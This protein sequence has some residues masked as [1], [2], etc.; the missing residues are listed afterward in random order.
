VLKKRLDDRLNEKLRDARA[1][2]DRIVGT[3]KNKAESMA[4]LAE[5]RAASAGPVL[6]TGDVG[7]LRAE[8][9][10]ALGA[11]GD[12]LDPA[13]LSAGQAAPLSA[14]PRVGDRVF[15]TAFNAEGV[16]RQVSGKHVEVEV[17]GKRLRAKLT[18]LG[19]AGAREAS[20]QAGRPV[21]GGVHV[22]TVVRGSEPRRDLVLVGSTVDDAIGRVEKFLDD[23]LLADE[24]CVR[25]VHG[26]GTGR[27]REALTAYLREH[28]LVA[29]LSLAGEREGG[30]AATI[31]ELKD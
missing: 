16:V 2:V 18:D 21:S 23:A 5:R 13:G 27:L 30:R 3:L 22:D 10:A 26:Q 15:V 11:L 1:E 25:I 4:A 24:R 12:A 8:A 29:S 7:G 19:Q 31:V 6:S 17:K 28:P 20:A 9:R 14:P